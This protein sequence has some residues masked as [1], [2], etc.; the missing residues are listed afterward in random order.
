MSIYESIRGFADWQACP[1][2]PQ[3]VQPVSLSRATLQRH[4]A[5]SK[6]VTREAALKAG[7]LETMANML[8]S[9]YGIKGDHAGSDAS[10]GVTTS[11]LL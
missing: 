11:R 4:G 6:S 7:P 5:A 1:I 8:N 2:S 10:V 3:S 9:A